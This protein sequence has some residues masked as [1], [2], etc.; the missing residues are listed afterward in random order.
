MALAQ[1]LDPKLTAPQPG[2]VDAGLPDL[3][4]P[5]SLTYVSDARCYL[6]RDDGGFYAIVAVCTHLG[7]T[8]RLEGDAFV[9]PCH[10][11]RFTREGA[12]LQGP[13]TRPLDRALVGR[14]AKG[15]LFV[16]RGRLV[17]AG[18]RFRV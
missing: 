15:H 2:P 5:G 4:Q 17:D 7:C 12:V 3:Y 14:D 10:G 11:S 8:P 16:H 9:C 13:A 1:F 18:F 6:G